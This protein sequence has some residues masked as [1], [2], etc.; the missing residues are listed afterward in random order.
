MKFRYLVLLVFFL[1]DYILCQNFNYTNDD[2]YIL[3]NLSSINAISEDNLNIY[4]ATDIGVIKYEKIMEDFQFDYGLFINANFKNIRHMIYDDF[5]D[6]FWIVHS[7]GISYKSS[8]SSI[9]RELSLSTT[10]IFNIYE[11]DDLGYSS[12]YVWIRSMDDLYPFDPFTARLAKWEDAKNEIDFINWGYSKFGISGK[13]ID[14]SSFLIEGDWLVGI[15][16]IHSIKDGK[17]LHPSLFME[18]QE[19]NLWFGTE[20][21]FILKGWR[22]SNRLDLIKIGIPFNNVTTSYFDDEGVWWFADSQFKRTGKHLMGNNES[23]LASW[24]ESENSWTYYDLNELISKQNLDVNSIKRIGSIMYFGTMS[25]LLY[26]DLYDLEWNMLN[27]SNGLYDSAIWD[28]VEYDNSIYLATSNGVNEVSIINHS[29]IPDRDKKFEFLSN[30]SIYDLLSDSNTFYLATN[31]GLFKID[32]DVWSPQ[33]ITKKIFKKIKIQDQKIFGLNENLW[34]IDVG[35]NEELQIL[36]NIH[37]F[38]VCNSHIWASKK[39]KA[40]VLNVI[41][42]V[43]FEYDQSDGIPGNK[44]FSIECDEKWVWFSTNGGVAFYKWGDYHEE[45]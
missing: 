38:D 36:T 20:E 27:V 4:F 37:D 32:W 18:D 42:N 30:I 34:L 25:G 21:G 22:H 29:I 8:I 16:R 33:L 45:N 28:I 35:K 19:R 7:D 1:K 17:E 10:R 14:M 2:W 15:N 23:F 6:Y 43:D 39:N 40:K 11:I 31:I 3:P 24:K 26:L 12:E 13:N 9:W 41:T 44:I 5:R